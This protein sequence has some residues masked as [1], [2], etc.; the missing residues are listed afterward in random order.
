MLMFRILTIYI[1]TNNLFC[2]MHIIML[3][4]NYLTKNYVP[5]FGTFSAFYLN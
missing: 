4:I 2:A 3:A 1:V 5:L